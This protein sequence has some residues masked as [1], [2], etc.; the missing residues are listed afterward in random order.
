MKAYWGSGVIA[1]RILDLGTRRSWVVSFTAQPLYPHGKNPWYPLYW[2]LSGPEIRSGHPFQNVYVLFP[3]F[4]VVSQ[5]PI[6][7]LTNIQYEF[8]VSPIQWFTKS[9]TDLWWFRFALHGTLWSP[10]QGKKKNIKLT[11]KCTFR[12]YLSYCDF[13]KIITRGWRWSWIRRVR[14]LNYQLIF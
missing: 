8:L 12:N 2:R 5:L 3:H 10:V 11:C 14:W 6:S 9:G 1:S 7:F 13:Y 4:H